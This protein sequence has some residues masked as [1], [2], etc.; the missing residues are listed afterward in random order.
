MAPPTSQSSRSLIYAHALL[1]PFIEW[2]N[3]GLISLFSL[4]TKHQLSKISMQSFPMIL[5]LKG[6]ITMIDMIYNFRVDDIHA[7]VFSNK[8]NALR[9]P[10]ED[11][12]SDEQID[13]FHQI[14]DCVPRHLSAVSPS[15]VSDG[16]CQMKMMIAFPDNRCCFHPRWI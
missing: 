3:S 4:F 13:L 12:L 16:S 9:I 10:F 7:A 15:E 6:N 1:M 2:A 14:L 8:F 5:Y 11:S